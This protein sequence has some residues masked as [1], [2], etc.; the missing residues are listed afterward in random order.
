MSLTIITDQGI[1]FINDAIK[2]LTNHFLMKHVSFT[3]Y[4]PQGNGQ[5]ESINKVFV[6]L[7]TKLVNE[8]RINWDEHVYNVIFIQN[9][10]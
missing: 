5:A 3:T 9:C 7:L 6:T 4:Y 2:Y 1:H 8:N 10:I